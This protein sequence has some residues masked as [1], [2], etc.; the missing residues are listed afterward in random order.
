MARKL[1][2]QIS[3]FC[4]RISVEKEIFLRNLR[5]LFSSVRFAERR[6][7]EPLPALIKGH[8][9]PM[10]RQLNGVDMQLQQNKETNLR[11]S[12]AHINGIVIEPG[13]T[14]SFW[15]TVG[16][17]T[18]KKGYLPG[19]TIGAGR[20]GAD[21][22]GGLCQMANLIHWMVLNSPLTVTELHHHTDALF[23]DI[24]P[25]PRYALMERC[26]ATENRYLHENPC[27]IGYPKVRETMEALAKRHRLFIVSNSQQGY[28]ELC[29]QKMG[30]EGCISGHLCF[31]DTGTDKGTTIRILLE[32]YGISSAVYVG[33]TQGD[34]EATYAA[35][36]PFVWA[37][38]G[39]GTPEKYD[40]R[41][42]SF[43]ELLTLEQEGRL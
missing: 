22:G 25:E 26:M 9:S 18:A 23:P 29:I 15:H 10:L 33:D 40:A 41:I 32:K 14:F 43:E 36:L 34:M 38:Y 11:L 2:C 13:E 35:G 7:T 42:S 39:F 27:R 6:E 4:Y 24:A 19:L 8:R 17:T 28:P 16:R 37:D 12:G 5:D 3:P 21:T 31:G 20:L 30:L 1:F